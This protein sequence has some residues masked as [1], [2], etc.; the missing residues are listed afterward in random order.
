[1]LASVSIVL[2]A[3]TEID[4][5]WVPLSVFFWFVG[6]RFGGRVEKTNDWQ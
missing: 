3:I 2:K 6:I 1:L 5:C 4:D